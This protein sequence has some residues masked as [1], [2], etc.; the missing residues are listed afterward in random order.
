MQL[1]EI[2]YLLTVTGWNDFWGVVAFL[3]CGWLMIL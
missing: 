2:Y 1:E 3:K